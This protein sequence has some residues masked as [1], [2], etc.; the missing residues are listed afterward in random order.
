M[1]IEPPNTVWQQIYV[2]DIIINSEKKRDCRKTATATYV[3]LAG[4]GNKMK[5]LFKRDDALRRVKLWKFVPTENQGKK[6]AH[7][8]TE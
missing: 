3:T 1:E 4:R 6:E 5:P 2:G 7:E 8:K